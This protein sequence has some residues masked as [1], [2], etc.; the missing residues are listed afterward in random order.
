MTDFIRFRQQFVLLA[1]DAVRRLIDGVVGAREVDP[2]YFVIWSLALAVTPPWFH[3]FHQIFLYGALRTAPIE[4]MQEVLLRDR[5]FF[6]VYGMLVAALYTVTIWNAVLPDRRELE[7]LGALPI[8][9]RTI[10]LARLAAAAGCAALVSLAV[11]VPSALFF[12]LCA[13]SNRA[14]GFFGLVLVAHLL[15]TTAASLFV[16]GA[17]LTV[18]GVLAI[19]APPRIADAVATVL[20]ASTVLGLVQ[21]LFFLP[22]LLTGMSQATFGSDSG[23]RW[24]PPLWF[25]GLYTWIAGTSAPGLAGF[26]WF[27]VAGVATALLAPVAVLALPAERLALRALERMPPP[28]RPGLLALASRLLQAVVREPVLRALCAFGVVSLARSQRHVL[29]LAGYAGIAVAG[30]GLTMVVVSSIHGP[31]P[32]DTPTATSMSLPLIAMFCAVIGVRAALAVPT[33]LQANW[34]F[35][36]TAPP[37]PIVV[38]AVEVLMLTLIVMPIAALAATVAAV[39][40]WPATAA[41]A[42]FGFNAVCGALLVEAS[43]HGWTK[44]PFASGH[45][46]VPD[47]IKIK[48]PL[49]L[50]SLLAYAGALGRLQYLAQLSP[51]ASVAFVGLGTVAVIRI[52][53][54]ILGSVA[55]VP[56]QFDVDEGNRPQVLSLSGALH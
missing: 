26:A 25:A 47:T 50:G 9:N 51:W 14:L 21:V 20:Q 18:R 13:I 24:L 35:Q 5:L 11:A 48:V 29:I 53:R 32:T 19:V 55:N 1:R 4:V 38:R 17:L 37:A 30:I 54:A 46:A 2:S 40:G 3:S 10:V 6:L 33:E 56:L 16:W 28:R 12:V 8:R 45:A 44:V 22:D 27:A 49:F 39:A 15:C 31:L 52:R 34:P 7:T 36:M 42:V 23:A 43:L 41:A